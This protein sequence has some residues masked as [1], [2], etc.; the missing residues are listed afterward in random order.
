MMVLLFIRG[1]KCNLN[2]TNSGG[3]YII[4]SR[5]KLIESGVLEEVNDGYLFKTDRIF[6]SPS[7]ASATVLARRSSGWRDW[8]NI[9]GK[10]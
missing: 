3:K 6:N 2:V 5:E 10:T 9:E 4:N 8:K 7:A 1:S